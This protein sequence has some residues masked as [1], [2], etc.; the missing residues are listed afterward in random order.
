MRGIK[1]VSW[2]YSCDEEYVE[3]FDTGNILKYSLSL[4]VLTRNRLDPISVFEYENMCMFVCL[5]VYFALML[6][7]HSF[8]T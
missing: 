2:E 3:D 7:L 4:A 8:A 6:F 5:N 1:S